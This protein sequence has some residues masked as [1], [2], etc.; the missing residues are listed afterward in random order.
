M[1][2]IFILGPVHYNTLKRVLLGISS[3]T[4]TTRLKLLE[5]RGIIERKVEQERPVRV[6]YKTTKFGDDFI[7]L[8]APA[9][10]YAVAYQ[11]DMK[12]E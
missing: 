5:K 9:L 4:L 8:L 11:K 10:I 6:T 12:N 1:Y 7:T 2:L 3:R